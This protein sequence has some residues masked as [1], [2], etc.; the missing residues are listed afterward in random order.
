MTPCKVNILQR[1]LLRFFNKSMDKNHAPSFITKI[2]RAIPLGIV[3]RIQ[4]LQSHHKQ[5]DLAK[6]YP[7]L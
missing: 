3:P 1:S 5:I 2:T 4:A 6:G 7:I